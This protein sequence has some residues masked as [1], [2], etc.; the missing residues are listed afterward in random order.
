MDGDADAA[1]AKL[2]GIAWRQ[3]RRAQGEELEV[4]EV[5]LF[6]QRRD[7]SLGV[8]QLA[9]GVWGR[10]RA[11]LACLPVVLAAQGCAAQPG[12]ASCTAPSCGGAKL[13][14]FHP[15]VCPFLLNC[16][17]IVNLHSLPHSLPHVVDCRAGG[18]M[19]PDS[20]PALL[21]ALLPALPLSPCLDASP[22]GCMPSPD[23]PALPSVPPPPD[24]KFKW[25][26]L[27]IMK[28]MESWERKLGGNGD[29]LGRAHRCWL[30]TQ[31]TARLP[32]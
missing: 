3:L 29:E 28:W 22:L 8:R 6:T 26:V 11:R 24:K 32:H 1:L 5:I 10:G 21:P 18:S 30:S 15:F 19:P 31:G 27:R 9:A 7:D 20:P 16:T 12:A 17:N 13:L 23:L 25:C 14:D 2:I 4:H